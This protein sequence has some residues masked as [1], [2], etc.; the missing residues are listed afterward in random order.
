VS[1]GWPARL[2]HVPL[3]VWDV[4]LAVVVAVAGVLPSGHQPRWAYPAAFCAG[5]ALVARRRWPRLVLLASFPALIGG[6]GTFAAGAGLYA[7]GRA[8]PTYRAVLPWL[9]STIAVTIA[10]VAYRNIVT[11]SGLPAWGDWVVMVLAV[12]LVTSGLAAGGALAATRMQLAASLDALRATEADRDAAVAARVR[13]E[14]RNRI[15][16]EVHDIVGHYA[17]L[18]AVQASALE[19]HA[20]DPQ[21]KDTAVRLRELSSDAL[22]EMRSAVAMWQRTDYGVIIAED[23]V[24]W[25]LQPAVAARESGVQLDVR[26]GDELPDSMNEGVLRVLRRAVQEGV[27]NAVRHCP[28]APVTVSLERLD[29]TVRLE[30]S[31]PVRNP[32]VEPAGTP[33]S[34]SGLA[35]L[36]ERVAKHG[37]MITAGRTPDGAHWRLTVIV[38]T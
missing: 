8:R 24:P 1:G 21:T 7:L 18:I 20:P 19:A 14:E 17:A 16:R 36:R 13:A 3:W 33:G 5:L 37:G 29:E 26:R 9:V 38:K 35:G 11:G 10:P 25:V 2:Q 31:N 22:E 32:A 12:V 23:W 4:T 27:T 15:A 28:D 30:V 34:G 6:L